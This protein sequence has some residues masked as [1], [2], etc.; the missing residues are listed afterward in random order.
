M[1]IDGL[2]AELSK[3]EIKEG[4][5]LCISGPGAD[6]LTTKMLEELNKTIAEYGLK[7]FLML[8]VPTGTQIKDLNEEEMEKEGWIRSTAHGI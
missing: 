8:I 3:L 6:M 5:V 2:D 4:S 1:K 7:D